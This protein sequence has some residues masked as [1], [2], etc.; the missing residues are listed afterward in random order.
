MTLCTSF[1]VSLIV[2]VVLDIVLVARHG[3]LG[4]AVA[5][6]CGTV[7]GLIVVVH[8]YRRDGWD[9]Q[10]FR[11]R[12]DDVRALRVVASDLGLG[13]RCQQPL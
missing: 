7:A 10:S 12:A 9:W 8:S 11:P 13:R 1:G 3:E 4:A 6:V 5:A 2:M